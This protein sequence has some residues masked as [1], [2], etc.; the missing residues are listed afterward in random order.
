MTQLKVEAE[1]LMAALEKTKTEA[2]EEAKELRDAL[3]QKKGELE[4][5]KRELEEKSREADESMDKYCSLMIKAHRLEESNEGLKVR[6]EQFTATRR[7]DEAAFHSSLADPRRRSS[8]KSSSKQQEAERD[9]DA[10]N[11]VPPAA[12]RP[13][14]GSSPGKRGHGEIGDSVQ[15]VLHNL[16]KKLKA[17]AMTTPKPGGGQEEDDFRPE[18]LPELVQKGRDTSLTPEVCSVRPLLGVDQSPHNL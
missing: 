2:E 17:G 15:E 1:D 12:Q 9:D 11:L 18:G 16:T 5:V 14:Q 7:A 13:L 4:E 6:L 10:E 3:D 8:R